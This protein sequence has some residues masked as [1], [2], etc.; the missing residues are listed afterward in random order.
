[1]GVTLD[2]DCTTDIVKTFHGSLI[3]DERFNNKIFLK[4]LLLEGQSGGRTFKYGY[5]IQHGTVGRDRKTLENSSQESKTLA[6]IWGDAIAKQ[7][8]D[9]LSIY[10]KYALGAAEMGRCE[11]G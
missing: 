4:G 11:P 2:L 9:T 1:V 3:L 5:D 8:S 6:N 7:E 10:F